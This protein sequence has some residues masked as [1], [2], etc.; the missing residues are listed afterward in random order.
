MLTNSPFFKRKLTS[1]RKTLPRAWQSSIIL[2][3][4][5]GW[6]M[7]WRWNS[8]KDQFMQTFKISN[9]KLPNLFRVIKRNV[10]TKLWIWKR[11]WRMALKNKTSFCNDRIRELTKF[12]MNARRK[13]PC[14]MESGFGDSTKGLLSTRTCESCINDASLKYQNLN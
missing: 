14:K 12:C 8:I 7:I 11:F 2:S 10:L 9:Q 5:I 13:W 4:T 3:S 1:W 6:P